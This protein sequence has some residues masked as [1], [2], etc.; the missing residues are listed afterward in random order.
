MHVRLPSCGP[1][2]SLQV[3]A[4]EACVPRQKEL[5]LLSLTPQQKRTLDRVRG[6]QGCVAEREV[7]SSPV[8]S[9]APSE[10]E[11]GRLGVEELAAWHSTQLR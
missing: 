5:L 3:W 1:E 7:A 4:C 10:S 2:E 11:S 8:S 9:Q 6:E